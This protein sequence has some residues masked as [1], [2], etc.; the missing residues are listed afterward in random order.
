MADT[1]SRGSHRV[2]TANWRLRFDPRMSEP[3]P[4]R[5][6]ILAWSTPTLLLVPAAPIHAAS[7]KAPLK[8]NYL[9]GYGAAYNGSGKPTAVESGLSVQSVWTQNAPTLTSITVT[10]IYPDDRVTGG[11]A[12]I[13]AGGGAWTSAGVTHSGSSY[14]YT[15]VWTG[16]LAPGSSTTDLK[17]RVPLNTAKTGSFAI[18]AMA[19]ATHATPASLSATTSST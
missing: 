12:T 10:V 17:F 9:N 5:R 15:F 11:P 2:L 1:H 6:R 18:S 13:T 4:S 3:G 8:F 7:V 14:V 19:S 16:S